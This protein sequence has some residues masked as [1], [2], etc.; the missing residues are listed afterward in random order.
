MDKS[1]CLLR[2][3]TSELEITCTYF[4]A[5]SR[6]RIANSYSL[7]Q[8]QHF[9]ST[10]WDLFWCQDETHSCY[11][12]SHFLYPSNSHLTMCSLFCRPLFT[13]RFH[14]LDSLI[15]HFYHLVSFKLLASPFSSGIQ[16]PSY[17]VVP[18]IFSL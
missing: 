6:I 5:T 11:F 18:C 9:V 16:S 8:W 10:W 17:G 14:C 7:S 12:L 4:L 1:T 2:L 3:L 13:Y 15:S